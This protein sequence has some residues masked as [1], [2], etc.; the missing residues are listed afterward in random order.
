MSAEAKAILGQKTQEQA[1]A[2]ATRNF[3]GMTSETLAGFEQAIARALPKTAADLNAQRII[4]I[5]TT[6]IQSNADLRSCTV[7]SV[8]GSVMQAAIL[9]FT[10]LPQLAECY[11][12]PRREGRG[13]N[14]MVCTFQIGYK[15][16]LNLY[17]RCRMV[18]MVRAR[19][20]CESD[21]FDYEFGLDER[22]RHKVNAVP[23][24]DGSNVTHAYAIVDLVT[25]G[26]SFVVM[27][28]TEIDALKMRGAGSSGK[29][30][31]AWRSDYA[32]MALAKALKALKR[33]I[34]SDGSIAAAMAT[35]EQALDPDK[36]TPDGTYDGQL[37]YDIE[38]DSEDV[39]ADGVLDLRGTRA[40]IAPH[41]STE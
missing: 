29:A 16:W 1:G 38:D 13:S 12:I 36:F 37:E 2:A 33:Y 21:E 30:G 3:L 20:V 9:G 11:L 19:V 14:T 31:P 27:S 23:M 34:P 41:P 28:K 6:L 17:Y 25:G 35:D 22:L 15:G 10:P 32:S 40:Q 39:A 5:A 18:K 7:K 4:Q 8:L 26:R 24:A